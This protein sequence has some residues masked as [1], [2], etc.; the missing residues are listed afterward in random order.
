MKGKKKGSK[1]KGQSK[2]RAPQS[3]YKKVWEEDEID[4]LETF[5]ED[6]EKFNDLPWVF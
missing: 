1:S 2:E 5:I 6:F 4:M 3:Q